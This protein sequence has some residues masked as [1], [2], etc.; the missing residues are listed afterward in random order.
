V[1]RLYNARFEEIDRH[2]R[3]NDPVVVVLLHL[4]GLGRIN[5][6]R[7]RAA[8]DEILRALADILLKQTRVVNVV[9]RHCGDLFAVVPVGRADPQSEP[10]DQR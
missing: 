6:E 8:G 2:R 4:D 9:S 1:T 7:G 10:E 5:D 3:S